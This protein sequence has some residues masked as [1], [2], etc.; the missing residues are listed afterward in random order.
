MAKLRLLLSILLPLLGSS[1]T[2][3][4]SFLARPNERLRVATGNS[5]A[6]LSM[7]MG[8]SHSHHHHAHGHDNNHPATPLMRPTS[9]RRKISLVIF[10]ACVVLVPRIVMKKTISRA[11]SA[12]FILTC[13][14]LGM[15][16]QIRSGFSDIT[17]KLMVSFEQL[18]FHIPCR[19]RFI[20]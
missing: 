10:A 4:S 8:H 18:P 14:A 11:H 19:W 3:H 12:T 17:G 16:D 2:S 6:S 9:V 7:H 1:F 20:V 5:A 15:M 13:A